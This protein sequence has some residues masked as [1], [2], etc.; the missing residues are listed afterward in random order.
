MEQ[1]QYD[2]SVV[3]GV[4]SALTTKHD[5]ELK[6]WEELAVSGNRE[7]GML[8]EDFVEMVLKV[9]AGMDRPQL[10]SRFQQYAYQVMNDAAYKV[11]V[12]EAQIAYD[13]DALAAGVDA[14]SE[15]PQWLGDMKV[16]LLSEPPPYVADT[17]IISDRLVALQSP[18]AVYCVS[19]N[20]PRLYSRWLTYVVD[21]KDKYGLITS[22]DVI[23]TP[24]AAT[25]G[26]KV[27]PLTGGIV[28]TDL[29]T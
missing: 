16:L 14:N 5:F 26:V 15:F 3:K 19:H 20:R 24:V 25:V 27:S 9:V 28:I 4:V 6:S 10:L 22:S 29:L 11:L 21:L 2:F 17:T 8:G 18:V 1:I 13:F 7:P 23:D 12:E